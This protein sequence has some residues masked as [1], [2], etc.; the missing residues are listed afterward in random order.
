VQPK[1]IMTRTIDN[2]GYFTPDT[3][4]EVVSLLN[5][6]GKKMAVL[7]GGTDLIRDLKYRAVS[8]QYVMNIKAIPGMN[9]IRETAD[10]GVNIGAL[11]TIMNL[12]MSEIIKQKYESLHDC[13]IKAFHS[14]QLKNV[15][16]LGG[17]ICR[18]SPAADA[19]PPLV[20]YDAQVRLCGPKGER[21][22]PLEKFFIGPGESILDKEILVEVILPPQRGQYGAAFTSLKRTSVDLCKLNCAVKLVVNNGTC[23]D[24]RIALGAVGPTVV[25]ARSVEEA[26]R[27]QEINEIKAESAAKN[28]L[29]D[30]SPITDARSTAEYRKEVSKVIVRRLILKAAERARDIVKKDKNLIH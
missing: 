22:M 11:T 3:L 28:V 15:A 25:R 26:L 18:S 10:G 24:I 5:T 17:N 14:W 4:E 1:F 21:L 6:Y 29:E 23:E 13:T 12:R 9:Q 19:V 30:I 27:G 16:T 8:P 7:A 20:T 2:F